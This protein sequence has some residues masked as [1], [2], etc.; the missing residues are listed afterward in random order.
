MKLNPY[1]KM[2]FSFF[3]E[4]V[5]PTQCDKQTTISELLLNFFL[6]CVVSR[7]EKKGKK[8]LERRIGAK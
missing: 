7:G 2:I 1:K 3:Y 5:L 8:N 4:S 6:K